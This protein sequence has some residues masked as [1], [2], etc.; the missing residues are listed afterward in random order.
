MDIYKYYQTSGMSEMG[1]KLLGRFDTTDG[2][3]ITIGKDTGSTSNSENTSTSKPSNSGSS[4]SVNGIA[5]D[6]G[7]VEHVYTP[8]TPSAS[9]SNS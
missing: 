1:Y 4:S 8:G 6:W 7:K 2:K 9:Y 3:S 5:E